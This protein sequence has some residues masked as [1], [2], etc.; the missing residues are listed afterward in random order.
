MFM[1]TRRAGILGTLEVPLA[2]CDF[3]KEERWTS[4]DNLAVIHFALDQGIRVIK[5]NPNAEKESK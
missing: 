2:C 4:D 1:A 3:E 5:E